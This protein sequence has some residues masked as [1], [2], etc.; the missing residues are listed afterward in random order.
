[1]KPHL[2]DM[3]R[4]ALVAALLLGL[5]AFAVFGFQHGFE[6]S[7][8]WYLILLPGALVA[9]SISDALYKAM[10][11]APTTGALPFWS[12]LISLNFLWYFGIVFAAIKGYRWLATASKVEMPKRGRN[13]HDA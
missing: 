11:S 8:T 10:P 7:V 4:A 12:L 6:E 3:N 13:D 1:M 2:S 9:G 5:A